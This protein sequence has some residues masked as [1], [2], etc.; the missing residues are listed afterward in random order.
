MVDKAVQNESTKIPSAIQI[1]DKIKEAVAAQLSD[2]STGLNPQQVNQK[3][4]L[5]HVREIMSNSKNFTT[6]LDN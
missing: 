3:H 5:E 4:I 2:L 1:D 6:I